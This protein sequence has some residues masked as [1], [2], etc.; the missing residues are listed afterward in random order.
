MTTL[1]LI[2]P[3]STIA[4]GVWSADA[5]L[6][7]EPPAP[8]LYHETFERGGQAVIGGNR[9]S[10]YQWAA[11]PPA[12]LPDWNKYALAPAELIESWVDVQR[13]QGICQIEAP[14]TA[15]TFSW[16]GM[17]VPFPTPPAYPFRCI[18]YGR[19]ALGRSVQEL[20]SPVIENWGGIFVSFAPDLASD[21]AIVAAGASMT[22]TAYTAVSAQL[23]DHQTLAQPLFHYPGASARF[24]LRVACNSPTDVAVQTD[25]C[26]DPAGAWWSAMQVLGGYTTLPK[27]MGIGG[28]AICDPSLVTQGMVVAANYF[29]AYDASGIAAGSF[30]TQGS[31]IVV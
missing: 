26:L 4:Q 23:T 1:P 30:A 14:P 5:S 10:A 21:G 31:I 17:V 7:H 28:A 16:A 24:R 11:P 19:I 20:A 22:P 8:L 27:W 2:W 29:R 12:G 18:I 25:C 3:P 9:P 13:R 15:S 6:I